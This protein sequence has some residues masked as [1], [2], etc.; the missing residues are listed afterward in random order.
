MIKDR[1][2]V[3]DRL[4]CYG[5]RTTHQPLAL[6]DPEWSP[7]AL[8]RSPLHG[9]SPGPVPLAPSRSAASPCCSRSLKLPEQVPTETQGR[10]QE[11]HM[12]EGE[13]HEGPH[14]HTVCDQHCVLTG[15]V[16]LGEGVLRGSQAALQKEPGH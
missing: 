13:E 5:T 1:L 11:P 8:L 16:A 3:Q 7:L 9:Y 15:Q 12:E 2:I 6:Q 10:G 4:R 14:R